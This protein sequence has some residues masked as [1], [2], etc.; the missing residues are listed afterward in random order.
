MKYPQN[1]FLILTT[2]CDKRSE[3]KYCFYNV[4]PE[5][6]TPDRL[7]LKSITSLIKQFK[8]LNIQNIYL[9]G[10]EPLLREDLEQIVS[11]SKD[12]SMNVFLLSNG[13][14]L[15][16]SR[17]KRLEKAGLDVFVLSLNDMDILD[18]KTIAVVS[19][20]KRTY[21]SIIYVLTKNNTSHINDVFDLSKALN[22]GLVFQPA[23]IPSKHYEYRTLN[24][25]G[26]K[27]FD[28][29]KLY[30]DLRTWAVD[31]GY[32]K[33]LELIYDYYHEKSMRPNSCLMGSDAIVIDSDGTAYPCFHRRDLICGNIFRDDV[34]EIF[35]KSIKY[36]EELSKAGCFGEHCISLHTNFGR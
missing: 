10:G 13:R 12:L 19:Q 16:S 24:M 26:I 18:R 28:W 30:T 34:A 33:Y 20:F 8:L 4:E 9:T 11:Y 32:E 31:F 5:I 36:G 14:S 35:D 25:S 29:S 3:C 1:I 17:V 21:L 6:R 7:D 15:D 2:K 23:Y 22:A 27:S